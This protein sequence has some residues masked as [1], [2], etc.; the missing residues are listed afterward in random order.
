MLLKI[1]ILVFISCIFTGG[2]WLLNPTGDYYEPVTYLLGLSTFFLEYIRRQKLTKTENATISSAEVEEPVRKSKSSCAEFSSLDVKTI[3]AQ[4]HDSPPY[5]RQEIEKSYNGIKL[6]VSGHLNKVSED[7]RDKN[8]VRVQLSPYGLGD[9]HSVYFSILPS[10]F[11]EIKILNRNSLI[12][13]SGTIV[14][15]SGEGMYV[16]LL[17]ETMFVE[18][19]A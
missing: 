13:V 18:R 9:F 8:K 11:P 19:H 4:I 16:D 1:E 14:G 3:I 2:L 17:P 10:E 7:Y 15:T 5:Q 6:C 12:K